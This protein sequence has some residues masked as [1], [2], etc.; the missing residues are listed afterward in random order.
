MDE[1]LGKQKGHSSDKE[2]QKDDNGGY[3]NLRR[4]GE[5]PSASCLAGRLTALRGYSR[6]TG[7]AV[8]DCRGGLIGGQ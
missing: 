1:I 6:G 4:W 3:S 7:H 5:G 8:P 2:V